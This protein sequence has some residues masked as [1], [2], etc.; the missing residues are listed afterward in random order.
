MK[1]V[2]RLIAGLS[3]SLF[4]T[5][6]SQPVG[7]PL[8]DASDRAMPLGFGLYVTPDPKQNPIDPPERFVG[9][10]TALDFEVTEEEISKDVPVFAIC[11]GKIA[12]SGYVEG[13]GGLLLQ[14]CKA[15]SEHVV[16]I[17]G[18]LEIATLPEEG[19]TLQKGQ[20]FGRLAPPYSYDS[21]YNRKHLHLGIHRG[22]N[23]EMRGYVQN[24]SDLKQ[25]I[26]PASVLPL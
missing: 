13:Y 11:K 4:L 10:H 25:F 8:P 15:G 17:Y 19:S 23:L 14:R 18:H 24:E 12:F 1:I 22:K 2:R 20:E 16:V 5:A 26:D 7:L 9:Y 3:L 6:C 21:G